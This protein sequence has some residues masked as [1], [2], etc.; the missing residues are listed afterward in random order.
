[1]EETQLSI[2]NWAD[3]TFGFCQ[4]E[5]AIDRMVEE[6]RE[7]QSGSV[8]DVPNECADIL[9]TL[10]RIADVFNFDLH[11]AVDHK[12]QINRARKWKSNGD[13]TGQHI[14]EG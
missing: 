9:I 10:Y 14:K 12:M 13:G 7:L 5:R 6:V 4:Q 2:T 8:S 11:A 1:M 3:K